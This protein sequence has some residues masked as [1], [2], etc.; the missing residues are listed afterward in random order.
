MNKYI[1]LA[2]ICFVLAGISTVLG[3]IAISSGN[4]VAIG[5]YFGSTFGLFIFGMILFGQYEILQTLSLKES[6]SPYQ[7]EH[8]DSSK[9][10]P[11]GGKLPDNSGTIS[12]HKCGKE[13]TPIRDG[14]GRLKND[15]AK[16]PG[17]GQIITEADLK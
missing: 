12:C 3:L 16:C 14:N 9:L 8:D 5:G 4:S 13:F 11:I 17:C 2:I 1:V 15:Y 7:E 10:K 6:N